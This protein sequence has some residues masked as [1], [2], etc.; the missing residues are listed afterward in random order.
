MNTRH[1]PSETRITARGHLPSLGYLGQQC[2]NIQSSV[3]RQDVSLVRADS[4]LELAII[5]QS[6][7]LEYVFFFQVRTPDKIP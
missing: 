2:D 6:Y 1:H 4:L 5:P 7:P 3:E